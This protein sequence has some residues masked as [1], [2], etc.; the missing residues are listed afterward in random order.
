M[1]HFRPVVYFFSYD[2]SAHIARCCCRG[3]WS[4]VCFSR[5]LIARAIISYSYTLFALSLGAASN[6]VDR[7]EQSHQ[8]GWHL[9][10]I[11]RAVVNQR[12]LLPCVFATLDRRATPICICVGT[13]TRATLH[14]V[15][16][17]CQSAH[18]IVRQCRANSEH[19]P[20]GATGT[21]TSIATALAG[22]TS[23]QTV[24]CE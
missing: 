16:S 6:A 10:P 19:V 1:F 9:I 24:Q 21:L 14:C 2:L 18:G 15:A 17:V 22:G 11:F 4:V 8:R 5:Q 12:I 3:C 23:C 20:L 7:S 13:H